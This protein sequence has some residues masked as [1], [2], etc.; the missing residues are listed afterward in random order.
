M[1]NGAYV[2][3]QQEIA[4][5]QRAEAERERLLA[6]ERAQARRQSALFR[7]SAELAATLDEVE[8][9]QR[10]VNGL[11]DTLGFDT[12]GLF[13]PRRGPSPVGH[14]FPVTARSLC[15]NSG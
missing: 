8:L 5:R 10:V 9:C 1:F 12:V 13:L 11:H 3:L 7:L 15:T 4:E 6:A 2:Q 14:R